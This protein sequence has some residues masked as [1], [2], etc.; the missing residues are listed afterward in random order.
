MRRIAIALSLVGS[1]AQESRGQ[2]ILGRISLKQEKADE[3][4]IAFARAT[5]LDARNSPAWA[6]LAEACRTVSA[7]AI[8]PAAAQPL[9]DLPFARAVAAERPTRQ[10]VLDEIDRLPP[11][12]VQSR[13]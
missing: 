5:K 11:S 10:A 4:V 2:Y 9:A 1:P 6:G 7:V 8:S 12:G 3:A 13:A